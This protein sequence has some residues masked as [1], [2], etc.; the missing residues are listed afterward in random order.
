M[1]LEFLDLRTRNPARRAVSR[2]DAQGQLGCKRS[3]GRF[4]WA[5]VSVVR[6]A[7]GGWE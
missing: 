5:K 1:L 6:R 3:W 7:V 2:S 4:L